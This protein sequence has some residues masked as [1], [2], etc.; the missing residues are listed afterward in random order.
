M[1]K[2]CAIDVAKNIQEIIFV[3]VVDKNKIIR[4]IHFRLE[5]NEIIQWN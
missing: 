2:K 5:S 1:R 4:S 3:F